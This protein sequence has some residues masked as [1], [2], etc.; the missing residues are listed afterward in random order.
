MELP[1]AAAAMY[2]TWWGFALQA[3]T[4]LAP[5]GKYAYSVAD[6]SAAASA[7]SRDVGGAY[8]QWSPIGMSQLFSAARQIG[9]SQAA[10]NAASPADPLNADTMAAEAPW[11]RSAADQAAMP[12]WQARTE[13]TY[14]D[15]GGVEQTGIFTVQI[16][17][18]LPSTVGSLR[19]QLELR[20]TDMLTSPPGTGTPRSGTLTSVGSVTLLQV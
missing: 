5:D 8:A 13:V 6:A 11:S 1:P 9:H 4:T 16:P 19:A 18:V 7:I 10:L 17:Q 15:E 12:V 14:T 2:S 20:I 3:A